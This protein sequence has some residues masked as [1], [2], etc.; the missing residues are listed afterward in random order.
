MGGLSLAPGRMSNYMSNLSSH[1]ITTVNNSR[2]SR[3]KNQIGLLHAIG[4]LTSRGLGLCR[5]VSS[6][7]A[8]GAS[9]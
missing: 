7:G 5:V 2:D 6:I 4:P 8:E 9:Q 3:A 1:H